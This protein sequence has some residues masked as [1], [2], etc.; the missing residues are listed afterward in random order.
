MKEQMF[1][2]IIQSINSF[3]G[4]SRDCAYMLIQKYKSVPVNSLHSILSEAVKNC[5]KNSRKKLY[6]GKNNYYKRYREAKECGQ[7][8]GIIVRMA[9]KA[10]L[11][12]VLL[13]KVVLEI[14][15]KES[16]IKGS[17]NAVRQLMRDTT[18]I[19]DGH[20]AY[21]I[22]LCILYDDKYG[23][24]ADS[25]SKSTGYEYEVKLKHYLMERKIAFT[26]EDQLREKGYDKT[27]DFKL[28]VPIAV[29]GFVINWI[30]SK[31]RFGSEQVHDTTVK[32]QY[33]SYWN[34]FGPGLV[35]YWFDFVETLLQS[36]EKK[37]II[38]NDF[39]QN[40]TFMD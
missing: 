35:I 38:M 10:G 15:C 1:N 18:L 13:A 6:G 22:Y 40:I 23:Y 33:L 3:K 29:D 17:E 24:I 31:A 4:L 5:I 28:Q 36:N 27:P 20:L 8:E 16:Q 2:D 34:R 25:F 7:P 30:E 9:A 39:P 12:P 32:E 37:F 26:D 14:Y 19:E 11:P 21:E